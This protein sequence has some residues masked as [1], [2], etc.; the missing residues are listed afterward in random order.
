MTGKPSELSAAV[1]ICTRNRPGILLRCLMC[2]RAQTRQP[3][4][5]IVVDNSDSAVHEEIVASVAE[6]GV[7]LLRFEGGL[8]SL[9]AMRNVGL[10][11]AS[12]DVVAYLDDD[13]FA[14]PIWLE[15]ILAGYYVSPDI[16]GVTGRIEQGELAHDD[17]S[18][19]PRCGRFSVIR[20]P[21]GNFNYD[22]TRSFTVEQFQGTNMTFLRS[23]VVAMGG[24]DPAINGGYGSSEDLSICLGITANGGELLY[25]PRALVVHGLAPREAGVPRQLASS[26]V[27][28]CFNTRCY[29]YLMLKYNLMRPWSLT[30]LLF[31]GVR[32]RRCIFPEVRVDWRTRF[33]S[34]I[35]VFRGFLLGIRLSKAD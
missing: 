17:G 12:S 22:T 5:I 11:E 9:P 28:A 21:Y 7:K 13:G 29:T 3:D 31:L 27:F 35:A 20:G 19:A 25:N 26:P 23:A 34:A 10:D 4:E 33:E 32:V 8:G 14:S 16:H 15:E 18:A 24:W 30:A 1:I 2:L 6:F